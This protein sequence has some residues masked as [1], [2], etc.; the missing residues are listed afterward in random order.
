MGNPYFGG[1]EI[2][3]VAAAYVEAGVFVAPQAD[4]GDLPKAAE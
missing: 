4:A 3:K 2:K 1:A